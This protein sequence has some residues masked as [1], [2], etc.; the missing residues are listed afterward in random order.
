MSRLIPCAEPGCETLV[1]PQRERCRY[2]RKRTSPAERVGPAG[3]R[4]RRHAT[5][6]AT[7]EAAAQSTGPHGR[8]AA[9]SPPSPNER[10]SP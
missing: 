9:A 1:E 10:K 7:G 4:R 6:P 5:P 8:S 3:G 2:H